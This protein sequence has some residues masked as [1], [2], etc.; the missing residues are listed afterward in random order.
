M[1]QPDGTLGNGDGLV[2]PVW[3]D[4]FGRETRE[5][6]PTGQRTDSHYDGFGRLTRKI[7]DVGGLARYTDWYHNRAGWLTRQS[8]YTDGTTGGQ[9]TD[10]AYNRAGVKTLVTYPDSGTVSFVLDGAGRRT[11]QTDPRGINIDKDYDDAGR[12]LTKHEATNVYL[13]IRI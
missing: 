6:D 2:T 8:G 4:T 5:D 10:Y 12:V 9:H 1:I 3:Y 13:D 7:E 11:R